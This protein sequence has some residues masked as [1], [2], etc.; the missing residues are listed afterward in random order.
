MPPLSPPPRNGIALFALM[1]AVKNGAK[2]GA[3]DE[4]GTKMKSSKTRLFEFQGATV[5]G[6]DVVAWIADD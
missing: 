3:D 4:D 6:D 5:E 2:S 1:L